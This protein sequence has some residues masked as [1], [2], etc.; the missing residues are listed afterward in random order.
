M[1]EAVNSAMRNIISAMLFVL[2][3]HGAITSP[4]QIPGKVDKTDL[5]YLAG[6]MQIENGDNSEECIFLTGAVILNRLHS[7]NWKGDTI[8]KII[9]ARGQYASVTVNGFRTK[10]CTDRVLAIAKYL[11][12]YYEP[13]VQVPAD[14]VYQG[15]AIN[16]KGKIIN[17]ERVRVYKKIDVPGQ[18]PEYFCYE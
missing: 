14:V 10:K 3:M 1:T 18:K 6:A 2:I 8:E 12:L 15:Q 7:D 9:T 4:D 16:G 11:L 13:G 17:G 5:Q